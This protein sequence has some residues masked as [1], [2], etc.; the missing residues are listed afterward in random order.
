MILSVTFTNTYVKVE[1]MVIGFLEQT[2]KCLK[3]VEKIKICTISI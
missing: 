3:S 1:R 2:L